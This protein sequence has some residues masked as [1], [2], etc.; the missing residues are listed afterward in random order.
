MADAHLLERREPRFAINIAIIVSGIDQNGQVFHE[1][2]V[3]TNLS[4]WGC[5]FLLSVEPRVD[6]ILAIRMVPDGAHKSE[7]PSETMFQVVRVI[8]EGE[9]WFVGAWKMQGE[10]VW[11]SALDT[12]AQPPAE[13]W[14]SRNSAERRKRR[15]HR[16]DTDPR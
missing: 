15:D 9:L 8:P 6:D 10:N 3:T 5:A 14:P 16:G 7:Y 4:E 11:G 1:R 2:S 12:A 13:H